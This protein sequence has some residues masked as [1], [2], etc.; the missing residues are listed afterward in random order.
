MFI[1]KYHPNVLYHLNSRF[2]CHAIISLISCFCTFAIIE[3]LFRPGLVF[4]TGLTSMLSYKASCSSLL[5]RLFI[6]T[7]CLIMTVCAIAIV[8]N[9]QYFWSKF[10]RNTMNVYMLHM[11]V[12]FTLSWIF[13]EPLRNSFIGIIGSVA[14][15]PGLC[16]LLF[17]D[18]VNAVMSI[19]L[20]KNFRWTN[21]VIRD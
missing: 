21:R 11:I 2:R 6:Y 20:L 5:I 9:K 16:L 7:I 8:P 3:T 12:I 15:V 1:H 10:G 4:E 17:S 14:L 13:L 18:S 19:V